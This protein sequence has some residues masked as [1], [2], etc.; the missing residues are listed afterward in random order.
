MAG[1]F[2]LREIRSTEITS[3]ELDQMELYSNR[4]IPVKLRMAFKNNNI[5]LPDDDEIFK[6]SENMVKTHGPGGFE[7]WNEDVRLSVYPVRDS[8]G[9]AIKYGDGYYMIK[10]AHKD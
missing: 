5:S 9:T 2:H 3:E 7:I 1:N 4:S 8:Y 6:L 10:F